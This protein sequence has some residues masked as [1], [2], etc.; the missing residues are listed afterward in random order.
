[1]SK[2][3]K[4]KII[5]GWV[6]LE[7]TLGE[8]R[9]IGFVFDPD[10]DGTVREDYSLKVIAGQSPL[11]LPIEALRLSTR[12]EKCLKRVGICKIRQLVKKT[13]LDIKSI[14]NLGSASL[15]EIK[16]R[17]A[18]WGL[19]F[20]TLEARTKLLKDYGLADNH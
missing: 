4:V 2:V 7:E 13:E 15:S 17:L 1:M 18:K 8:Y 10:W 20:Q 6:L 9:R 12:P 16:K 14:R 3:I 5:S 19:H 11:N